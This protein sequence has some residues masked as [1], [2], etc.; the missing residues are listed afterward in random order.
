MAKKLWQ[1]AMTGVSDAIPAKPP[2]FA[3][4]DPGTARRFGEG[5]P[6]P[7]SYLVFLTLLT[8]GYNWWRPFGP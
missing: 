5:M 3:S 2:F 8:C 7:P 1:Q 6:T 4:D